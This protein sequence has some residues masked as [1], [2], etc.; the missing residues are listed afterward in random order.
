MKRKNRKEIRKILRLNSREA[1]NIT[2]LHAI[3]FII[4]RRDL[5]YAYKIDD[6]ADKKATDLLDQLGIRW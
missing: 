4:S 5:G 2:K 3:D 1:T 6:V